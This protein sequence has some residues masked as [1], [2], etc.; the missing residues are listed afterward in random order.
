M[1]DTTALKNRIRAAV[2]ANDNQ[3]ITG[4]VLQQALLDIVDELNGATETEAS[5]RQNG[6][7]T[8]QQ[9]INTERERAQNAENNLGQRITDETNRAQ[10]TESTLQQAIDAVN[11]K[12]K[13]YIVF[14]KPKVK[15]RLNPSDYSDGR[16]CV[17]FNSEIHDG[18][19]SGYQVYNIAAQNSFRYFY[20]DFIPVGNSYDYFQSILLKNASGKV[21][22]EC[23]F[24][25]EVTIIIPI[26]YSV[27]IGVP[28][29]VSVYEVTDF[30]AEDYELEAIRQ[31]A[32]RAERAFDDLDLVD[33]AGSEISQESINLTLR[34]NDGSEEEPE[35][36]VLSNLLIENAS[37]EKAGLA[38]AKKLWN[39]SPEL[40]SDEIVKSKGIYNAILLAI[41]TLNVLIKSHSVYDANTDSFYITDRFGN[42][43]LALEKAILAIN[44]IASMNDSL[45]ITDRFGNIAFKC[46]AE[47]IDYP[48]IVKQSDLPVIEESIE[49]RELF[50]G[51]DI[52]MIVVYGQSNSQNGNYPLPAYDFKDALI[53]ASKTLSIRGLET[54][55][56][57]QEINEYLGNGFAPLQQY[58][59]S[60]FTC[61][62]ISV[63]WMQMLAAYSHTDYEKL[64]Q[65]L[66]PVIAGKV[67]N[68]QT[69]TNPNGAEYSQIL[70]GVTAAKR[71]ANALN[72]SFDMPSLAW[73]QGE[74]NID[75]APKTFYD[76]LW[77]FLSNIN[78]DIK[79][80]T[81][82][83]NDIIM[84]VYQTCQSNRGSNI[85]MLKLALD[86]GTDSEYQLDSG[87]AAYLQS[88]V[89]LIDRKYVHMSM[90]FYPYKTHETTNPLHLSWSD[91]LFN[92]FGAF[93]SKAMAEDVNLHDVITCMHV[94]NYTVTQYGSSYVVDVNFEVPVPPLQFKAYDSRFGNNSSLTAVD[95]IEPN[96]G[97]NFAN[98]ETATEFVDII[99]KVEIAKLTHVIITCNASP[100]GKYLTYAQQGSVS[101]GNLCDS[102]GKSETFMVGNDKCYMDNFCPMFSILI[103]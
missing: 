76:Y 25:G 4:P 30:Y 3:E 22:L 83:N 80:I 61:G 90:P 17:I 10:E 48:G 2:K 93:I 42:I 50:F 31:E 6:D 98:S 89:Q 47:G 45:Y 24:K 35:Y 53:F 40:D 49:V 86:T 64:Q 73:I 27:S 51:A 12:T 21:R 99:T 59:G 41:D 8:L 74:G 52:R 14:K 103:S 9:G 15:T 13:N 44:S 37:E 100:I 68:I 43:A 97:F 16:G 62:G 63:K 18:F 65:Q 58:S 71:Y 81:G 67:T 46:N 1:A 91:G 87:A 96:Y 84:T 82:Q 94:K 101:G 66:L 19:G 70:K 56:T 7:S 75:T 69:L 38:P 54:L 39:N 60:L 29:N 92:I 33:T 11:I 72:K 55:E 57:D 36:R 78:H 5:Q 77:V 102:A 26:G 32:E 23:S 88:G 79:A 95:G 85:A 28:S 20:A 34:K